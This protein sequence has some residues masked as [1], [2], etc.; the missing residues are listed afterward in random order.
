MDR[1]LDLLSSYAVALDYSTLSPSVVH[2][3]KRRV[4]DTLG[5]AIGCYSMAVPRIA[6]EHAAEVSST[7]GSTILGTRQRSSPELAAFANG[8]MARYLDFNDTSMSGNAGHPSDNIMALLAAAEYA[9][10]D[11]RTVIAAIVIAY[12][13]QGR[14][15]VACKDLRSNGWDNAVYVTL[16]SAAGAGRVL[17]L[18]KQQMANAIALAAVP[19]APMG[20]TRVGELSM[21]KGCTAPN[22]ARNGVFAALLARRGMTGPQQAFEGPRGFKKQLGTALQLPAFGGAGVPYTIE[23]DKFK[24][25]PCDYEAQCTLTPA[26]KLHG[27]LNGKLDEIEKI[28]IETYQHAVLISADGPAKWNPTSRETADHSI[29]YVFAAGLARGTLWLEDFEEERIKDT[30]VHAL[31]QKIGVRAT[32]ECTRDWPEAY[33]FRITVT[34]KSGERH[35]EEVRYAKGHPKNPMSDDEIEAKFLRLAESVMGRSKAQLALQRLWRLDDMKGAGE[36][37]ALFELHA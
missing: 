21:W 17:G 26:L 35:L 8:V 9:G 32:E 36:I 31:M 13:V 12:E 33:P 11:M 27:L 3:V 22:A 15:G 5:C 20:E 7:P 23:T 2:Q 37:M 30:K 28:D 18:N 34:M 4:I 1:I 14:F 16:S 24:Y 10:A 25:Y 29:P 6:R 19:N